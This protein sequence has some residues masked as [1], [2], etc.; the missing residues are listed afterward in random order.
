MKK[1]QGKIAVANAKLAYTHYKEVFQG[2][3]YLS[4]QEKGARKQ[5][6]LWA[7]TSTKNPAYPD[8]KYVDE[9]IGPN[10]VNTLPP[11]TL[12]AYLDHGKVGLTLEKD[13]IGAKEKMGRLVQIGI[14]YKEITQTLENQGVKSFADAFSDLLNSIENRRSHSL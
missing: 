3:R 12:N 5:R 1:I 11:I 4:L 2:E 6:A 7:S 8:T 10:T 9:L 13:V 14:S